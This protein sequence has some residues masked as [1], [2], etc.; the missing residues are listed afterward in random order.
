MY[1]CNNVPVVIK[2]AGFK[3][4]VSTYCSGGGTLERGGLHL[5]HFDFIGTGL[6]TYM[7]IYIYYTYTHKM[8]WTL[9]K[10]LPYNRFSGSM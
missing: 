9:Q 1:V 8:Q 4:C 2:W 6:L 10:L 7:Y 5:P 3:K